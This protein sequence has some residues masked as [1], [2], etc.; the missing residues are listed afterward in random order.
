VNKFN[1]K[2]ALSAALIVLPASG[3]SA[4]PDFAQQPLFLGSAV[5]PNLMFIIDDSGSMEFAFMPSELGDEFADYNDYI[6][7]CQGTFVWESR[8]FCAMN[9]GDRRYLASSDVN[10]VYY[11]PNV[12]Y[13]APPGTAG[14]VDF[15]KAPYDGYDSSSEKIDLSSEYRAIID[16]YGTYYG[17]YN[18]DYYDDFTISPYGNAGEAFYYQQSSNC[19]D[20]FSNSC[21]SLVQPIPDS[22]KQNFANWF[23][24]YRTRMMAA[25]AGIGQAFV[26]LPESFRLGWGRINKGSS[27]VDDASM[28]AIEQGVRPYNF[29]HSDNEVHKSKFYDWLYNESGSG[30]TPL[31]RALEGAGEYFETSKRAWA[32]N[33]DIAS[34]DTN[35]V[36]ECRLSYTILMSD[37]YYNGKSP[38][39]DVEEADDKSGSEITNQRGSRFTYTPAYPFKDDREAKTLA[40]V[41]MY[42]WKRDLRTDI[43]NYVPTSESN[44]AF[45]QHMV[46]YTVGLGVTGSVDPTT[47]FKAIEDGTYIDWWGGTSKQDKVNDMLHAAVNGRG[48]FFSASDPT[49]F[50]TE[51]KGTVGDIVNEAGSSTAVEFDVSSFQ[52]GALIFS[53]QFDPNGWTGDLKAAKLGGTNS[54]IVPDINK[55]VEN[56]NGWSARDILDK[57]DLS[58]NDRVIITYGNGAK[59]FRWDAQ[60]ANN[61]T[62]AQKNDLR[63]GGVTDAVAKQRLAF[64]RG[65]RSL[66]GTSGWRKRGSRLGSIVNSSPEFVGEPRA[67]W[68]DDAPFGKSGE[69]FSD[70]AA[71]KKSRTPVVYTGSN[72]GMLHGFNATE[73]GGNEVLAYIPEFV[74]NASASNAGLHFLIDPQYQHRYYVDLEIRQQDIYTKGKKADG[75]LTADEAWRSII[76]GGGRAGAKGIFALDVTDPSGFSE[77]NAEK[78]ALWEFTADDNARMGYVTQAPIIGMTKWGSDTRWTAFVSN[79]YNAAT[80]STGFFMLDIEGGMDGS[81]DSGDVRYVEFEGSGGDG[82]SPLAAF[83]TTGDY[84]IDRVYAGDLDGNMWVASVDS[85]GSWAAAYTSGGI[86]QPLFTTKSKQAITAAPVAAANRKVPRAGNVPNLMIY[87][88]TG[89]YLESGDVTSTDTQSVYGIWDR[90]NAGLDVSSLESRSITEGPL[91][92]SD[93]ATAKVRY[94]SGKELDFTSVKGWYV[95]LPITGERAIFSPQVRGEFVYLNSMIPDEN[96]CLGGGSGW[97]MVFGLDGRNPEKA[98]F[99]RWPEKIVGYKLDGLPNQ[100]TIMGNYRFTPGSDPEKPVDVVEIPPLSGSVADAGR[101]GWNELIND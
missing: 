9:I 65:D 32:D 63:F 64:I 57:R 93:G 31:R 98:A 33:P 17:Y 100:S 42:Y 80:E 29:E 35:P 90:G 40:D 18:G 55:A 20:E 70:F 45:W 51:L 56:G 97:A 87:F 62:T 50:A 58:T 83:D 53:T 61:L 91:T 73:N 1:L 19:S 96:P 84:L 59:G 36:R 22:K 66:E 99:L 21:Y 74:Y 5:A 79:G 2:L 82:L 101:R 25:K 11:N 27:T 23:S 67:I 26:D 44:P 52:Q 86:A 60:A 43:N 10:K 89:Q 77:A 68:P 94:S 54:P 85:N 46:T 7:E 71:S 78:I 92:G 13:P 12:T 34:S 15:E 30:G 4:R 95:D 16:Q 41:A 24:Y 75:S 76:V 69:W 47:A 14:N 81:W 6:G 39:D 28:R 37:G 49:T 48:N 3:Y 38:D 72:D 88:G 8:R